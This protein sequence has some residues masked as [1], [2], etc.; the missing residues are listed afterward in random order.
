MIKYKAFSDLD[1]GKLLVPGVCF[2]IDHVVLYKHDSFHN[3]YESFLIKDGKIYAV[4]LSLI[5][6][7]S[8]M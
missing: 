6:Y 8:I 5:V 4:V 7:Q 3:A 2:G 1:I